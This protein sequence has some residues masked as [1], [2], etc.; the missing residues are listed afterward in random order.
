MTWPPWEPK[1]GDLVRFAP[2]FSDGPRSE[3]IPI[4]VAKATM[5]RFVKVTV[6]CDGVFLV[7]GQLDFET[8]LAAAYADEQQ[9][10]LDPTGPDTHQSYFWCFGADGVLVIN[11]RSLAPA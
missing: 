3:R 8:K 4:R 11:R 9:G 2:M 7:L 5:E 1:V 10:D 6:R